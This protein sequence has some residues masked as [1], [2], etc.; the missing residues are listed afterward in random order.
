M[1][2]NDPDEYARRVRARP[3]GP[4]E[5]MASGLA[6]WFHGPYLVMTV[7]TVDGSTVSV[8]GEDGASSLAADLA[9]VLCTATDGSAE[10]AHAGRL[11]PEHPGGAGGA[12]TVKALRVDC[13]ADACRLVLTVGE[14]EHQLSLDPP[15]VVT[16]AA[17]TR[18]WSEAIG[19]PARLS[20]MSDIAP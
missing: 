13:D 20:R 8:S 7:N 2:M 6:L 15:Q 17:A 5:V 10:L 3:Y 12:A 16:L 19:T 9:D 18:V 4:V 11:V 14:V 1:S